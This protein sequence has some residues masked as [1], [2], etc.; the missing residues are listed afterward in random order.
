MRY[1]K[2]KHHR[3][4]I[5][6]K[7]YDYSQAGAYFVTICTKN[8]E[9]LFGEISDGKMALN[10]TGIVASEV[11]NG[12]QNHF[13]VELDEYV[14]MPNH[15]HGIII[16]NNVGAIH[17][18]PNKRRQMLIPKIL[19]YYKMNTAKHINKI[20]NTSGIPFWQRNYYEHIIRNEK[21]LNSIRE[22]IVNN[23]LTWYEDEEN[24]STIRQ[25][26]K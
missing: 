19:G 22:Y 11:W 8:R 1:D 24:P 4:S 7:E 13:P 10:D 16:I 12:L 25:H 18:L 23:P 5:R 21:E 9:C 6:L 15:V 3:R 20:H 26:E 17:E 14:I 2:E